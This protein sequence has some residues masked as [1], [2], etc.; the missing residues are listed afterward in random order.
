M[1]RTALL[2]AA[3]GAL[4]AGCSALTDPQGPAPDSTAVV[5]TDVET[6]TEAG[7]VDATSVLDVRSYEQLSFA[8][9]GGCTPK[10]Y[11]VVPGGARFA[12]TATAG[13]YDQPMREVV[14]TLSADSL[15]SF[16]RECTWELL[17]QLAG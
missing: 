3:L 14:V 15:G 7:S 17:G 8:W 9:Q 4:A 10:L 1:K 13:L 12:L 16:P 2:L 5:A 11:E 6:F